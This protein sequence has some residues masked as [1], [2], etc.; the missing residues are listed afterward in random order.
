MTN[1]T[2]NPITRLE[3]HGKIEI[4]LNNEGNVENAYFQVP[5]LRGFEKFCEGR[6]VEEMP[7]ITSRICGVCP[8]AHHMAST[9]AL[10][11]VFHVDPPP[12]A[13]KLRELF[14]N[15]FYVADHTTHFY[16]LAG[17][18]FVMGPNAPKAERNI[19]GVIGKVGRDVGASVIKHRSDAMD[20]VA[21]IG[22]RRIHP[23]C[24]LP[25]G[26]SKPISETERAR[27]EEI[28]KSEIEFAKFTLKL[29]DDLVL[30]NK[31]YANLIRSDIYTT[32]TYYMGLVDDQNRVNFYDGE[33]RVVDPQGNEFAKYRAAE[34]QQHLSEHVEPWTYL[35]YPYLKKVGWKGLVGGKDSGV[36]RATP[37]SRLNVAEGMATPLAQ[38]EYKRM[39]ETLGGKPVHATLATHWARLVEL[40]Y[41]AERMHE[42]SRDPEITSQNVRMIPT[43]TP[44][45]GVGIVE[46]P[47]GTLTH[48]YQTDEKGLVT[49]VNLIVGTTNNHAA[50]SIS[51]KQAA[52]GLIKKGNVSEGLLNMVEMAFRAYDPCLGCA[53]HT[54]PGQMPLE[55]NIYNRQ[56]MLLHS[57]RRP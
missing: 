21:M 39:Y 38:V 1:V 43:A 8:E 19:L 17:P 54:L 35:K 49:K 25:G 31:E 33:V 32:Q 26:V 15:A 16:I 57:L 3:G 53:T 30:G 46:A 22:G 41:A 29:F 44:D 27:I 4:F 24:G 36:Y 56:R 23:T 6:P 42:L 37:L 45:E 11:A 55:V 10:D 13:K 48:H 51:I 20:V 40:L 2:I 50:I 28:A 18:D 9:K 12:A 7:D 14:Y 52:Q 47:R 5:E 34:Y